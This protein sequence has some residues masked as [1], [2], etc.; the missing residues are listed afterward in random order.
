MGRVHLEAVC[1]VGTV[2]VAAVV[3][4]R[5]DAAQS[6]AA[7]FGVERAES[8][9][10]R[11]LEDKSIDAVHFCTPNSQHAP[12]SLEALQAGKH[13]LCEK[14]LTTSSAEGRQLVELAVDCE[15]ADFQISPRLRYPPL[16]QP[17]VPWLPLRIP[18]FDALTPTFLKAIPQPHVNITP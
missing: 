4:R 6:L 15:S 12:I 1:R 16:L 3:G 5:L 14:P 9:Y 11:I 8:D 13:V 7:A 18:L 17:I 10:R 2:D